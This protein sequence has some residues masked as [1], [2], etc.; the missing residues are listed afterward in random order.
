MY[1]PNSARTAI[2]VVA[3]LIDEIESPDALASCREVLQWASTTETL[4]GIPN[5]A[6]VQL[7]QGKNVGDQAASA[8]VLFARATRY[9]EANEITGDVVRFNMCEG[10]MWGAAAILYAEMIAAIVR[11][12]SAWK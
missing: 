10:A 5:P 9:A 11:H 3:N 1:Y 7:C 8:A 4:M 2:E 12:P 6:I